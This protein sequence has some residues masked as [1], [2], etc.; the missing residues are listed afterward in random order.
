[1]EGGMSDGRGGAG[2]SMAIATQYNVYGVLTTFLVFQTD[3]LE[4]RI[5]LGYV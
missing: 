5:S 4:S 2:G 3:T 1:M